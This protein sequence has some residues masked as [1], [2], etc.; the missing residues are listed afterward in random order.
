MANVEYNPYYG[1]FAI[2]YKQ[3]GNEPQVSHVL[4]KEGVWLSYGDGLTVQHTK[5]YEGKNWYLLGEAYQSEPNRRCPLKE[6]RNAT[7]QNIDEITS[8]WAGRWLLVGYDRIFT[9][10]CSLLKCFLKK[11]IRSSSKTYGY[12]FASNPII[13]HEVS[14]VQDVT[15]AVEDKRALELEWVVPPRSG[16]KDIRVLLP[17]QCINICDGTIKPREI[18][19]VSKGIY[20]Y[21]DSLDEL[22]KL[23]SCIL[24]NIAVHND[25]IW[26]PLTGGEDTR[27][28]TA[29]AYYAGV[30]AKTY[31][32]NQPYPWI[33]NADKK[34]PPIIAR[35]AGFEHHLISKSSFSDEKKIFF[36]GLS[37]IY[38][39]RPGTP[40]YYFVNGYWDHFEKNTAILSG[41]CGELGRCYLYKKLPPNPTAGDLFQI[42]PTTRFN[43]I[44]INE[45]VNWWS[46]NPRINIDNRDRF[47]WE[48]RIA[49]Q[50]GDIMLQDSFIFPFYKIKKIPMLNCVKAFEIILGMDEA[51]RIGGKYNRDI[52]RR[53]FPQAKD[54]P[55]NPPDPFH[56]RILKRLEQLCDNPQKAVQKFHIFLNKSKKSLYAIS[57]HGG[58]WQRF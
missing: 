27:F 30:D 42:V 12:F 11:V 32:F 4:I 29:I 55:Y 10:A 24:K 6:L 21:A 38:N 14:G 49:G 39:K 33:S 1:Q 5:N 47:Y 16:Y 53:V 3:I 18:L 44:A 28:V 35:L 7:L 57:R 17:S 45:L 40:Y 50:A 26:A 54:I 46:Q 19:S 22:I 48:A 23:Y 8:S 31:T 52:I 34:L 51:H 36:N 58:I 25:N 43:K 56:K 15:T 2:G 9:D 20:S 37:H 13:L 41:I